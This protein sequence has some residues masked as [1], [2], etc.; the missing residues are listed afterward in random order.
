MFCNNQAYFASLT[1]SVLAGA[2]EGMQPLFGRSYGAKREEDLMWYFRAGILISVIGSTVI[3]LLVMLFDRPLCA[4]F[5]AKGETMEYTVRY[6][7]QYAW[8]FIVAGANTMISTY[9]YSTMRSVYAITLNVF[10]SFVMDTAV[11]VGFPAIFG[12]KVVWF[13]YGISECFVLILAVSLLK[14]SERD[15]VRTVAAEE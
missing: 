3:V 5:G 12:S 8:A 2:S 9:L 11:I 4:L 10:R 14:I 6:L 1:M 7:P 15:S 13:T